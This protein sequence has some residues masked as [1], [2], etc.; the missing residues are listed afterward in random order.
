MAGITV[1]VVTGVRQVLKI[2]LYLLTLARGSN[3]PECGSSH[4]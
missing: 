2:Y 4:L 1:T 3:P